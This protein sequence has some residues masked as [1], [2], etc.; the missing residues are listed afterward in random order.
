M[1]ASDNAQERARFLEGSSPLATPEEKMRGAEYRAQRN[2][3]IVG[4]AFI[5]MNFSRAEL[6]MIDQ[7]LKLGLVPAEKTGRQ[8]A[9]V[10]GAN[11]KPQNFE[12]V[13]EDLP[14]GGQQTVLIDQQTGKR[15]YV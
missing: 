12:V 4:N 9:R 13:K 6:A 5:A 11:G 8:F 2:M 7:G 10:K 14:G 1:A 15:I 3:E